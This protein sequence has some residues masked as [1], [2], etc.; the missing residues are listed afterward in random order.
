[1]GFFFK[2]VD[3]D[4]FEILHFLPFD[5]AVGRVIDDESFLFIGAKKAFRVVAD[6]G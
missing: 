5:F 4:L 2:E 6:L 3:F 1:M